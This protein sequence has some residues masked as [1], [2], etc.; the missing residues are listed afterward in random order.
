MTLAFRNVDASVDDPVETWPQEALL[1]ALER[2][3]ISHWRRIARAIDADPWGPVA[4]TVEDILT[5]SRPYG[6]DKLMETAIERAR[7]NAAQLDRQEAA[8]RVAEIVQRSGLSISEF[9]GRIGTSRS[10]VSTY[11]SGKVS[12]S[13][14]MLMRMERT[15]PAIAPGCEE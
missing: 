2:G 10:R 15:F 1:A 6:V 3:S 7:Q 14:A 11:M 5:Y 13:A 9:A 12:P 8:A 4:R